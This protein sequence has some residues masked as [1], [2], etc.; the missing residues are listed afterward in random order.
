[1]DEATVRRF[2]AV[3]RRL[4]RIYVEV[5]EIEAGK[6]ELVAMRAHDDMAD[7]IGEGVYTEASYDGVVAGI[8]EASVSLQDIAREP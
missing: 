1:M 2:D 8:R 6:A 3:T 7:D 5:A 4:A